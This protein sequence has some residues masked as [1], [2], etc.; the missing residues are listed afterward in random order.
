MLPVSTTKAYRQ[1]QKTKVA[2]RNKQNNQATDQNTYLEL[3]KHAGDA[4]TAS[5]LLEKARELDLADR[6]L[7]TKSTKYLLRADLRLQADAVISHF[8]KVVPSQEAIDNRKK[9]Q[10]G[11]SAVHNLFD[12]QA[13]WYELE[14]GDS[15]LR[16]GMYSQA[17]TQYANVEK[18][19]T[20]SSQVTTELFNPVNSALFG[21]R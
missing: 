13:S 18:V 16:A 4:V 9:S 3:Q 5:A 20:P 21:F 10:E 11:T 8:T 15:Y 14:L 2:N 17:L 1:N 19:Y 7:N 6:Y 12:M